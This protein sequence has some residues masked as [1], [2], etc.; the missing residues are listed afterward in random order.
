MGIS[1][2][3]GSMPAVVSGASRRVAAPQNAS[4]GAAGQAAAANTD[5][6]S[7]I[8]ALLKTLESSSPGATGGSLDTY[9]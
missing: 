1:S 3:G 6:S 9:A 7:T 4:T 2:I 8:Q 5:F